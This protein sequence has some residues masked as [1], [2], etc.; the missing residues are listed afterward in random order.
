MRKL[1][2]IEGE[3][4]VVYLDLQKHVLG[5]IFTVKWT[6]IYSISPPKIIPLRM[7]IILKLFALLCT[8]WNVPW[9]LFEMHANFIIDFQNSCRSTSN[10][11]TF[12]NSF[13]K[14]VNIF[15][16]VYFE[17]N[18]CVW[19]CNIDLS[20]LY[21]PRGRRIKCVTAGGAILILHVSTPTHLLVLQVP[22]SRKFKQTQ[23]F[24]IIWILQK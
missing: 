17:I 19:W 12:A 8:L 23:T 9:Y 1:L 11:K 18:I 15:L 5:L 7:A 2:F 22:S 16:E 6:S 13:K 24:W 14:F 20:Y 21:F 4:I 3:I 10:T